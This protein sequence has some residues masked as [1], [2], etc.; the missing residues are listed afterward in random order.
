MRT[1][2]AL[3]AFIVGALSIVAGAKAMQGWNPGWNVIA[4]LPVYNFGMG[5]FTVALP[6]VLIWKNSPYAM[7]AAVVTL[8]IHGIVA[9]LLLTVFRSAVA[10]QSILAM[11]SRFI[12]WVAII[13]LFY[14]SKKG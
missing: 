2:A 12:A 9:L 5:L 8:A 4:W 10:T 11:S 13:A 1:A 7:G 3:L 6:A 14:F